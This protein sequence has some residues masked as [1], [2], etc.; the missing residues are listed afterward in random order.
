MQTDFQLL[1]LYIHDAESAAQIIVFHNIKTGA[2]IVVVGHESLTAKVSTLCGSQKLN[3]S[4]MQ[5]YSLRM[6]TPLLS[7]LYVRMLD[8]EIGFSGAVFLG[9]SV[10]ARTRVCRSGDA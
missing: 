9:A 7:M 5:F 10:W 3:Y 8:N 1:L 2:R 6:K 4:Q